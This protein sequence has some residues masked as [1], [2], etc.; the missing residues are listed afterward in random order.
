MCGLATPVRVSE[1]DGANAELTLLL[2]LFASTKF[3]DL[4]IATILRV[5]IFAICEVDLNFAI[6]R[7]QR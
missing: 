3:C 7:N 5:L 2:L 6:S 4:G 1:K